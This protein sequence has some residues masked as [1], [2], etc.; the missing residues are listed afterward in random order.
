M[1]F[2]DTLDAG[3]WNSRKT[4]KGTCKHE[5]FLFIGFFTSEIHRTVIIVKSAFLSHI[6]YAPVKKHVCVD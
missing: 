5:L 1:R 4:G 6:I 3:K 2:I